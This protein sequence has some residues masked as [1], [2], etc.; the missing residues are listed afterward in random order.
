MFT[1]RMIALAVSLPFSKSAAA[2]MSLN[3]SLP[4]S[5]ITVPRKSA[6]LSISKV[7]RGASSA[8][9]V[10]LT[11]PRTLN[12]PAVTF[13]ICAL[14]SMVTGSGFVSAVMVSITVAGGVVTL[15]LPHCGASSGRSLTIKV[16]TAIVL[17]PGNLPS[18][19]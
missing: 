4:P 16:A 12:T 11:V 18:F 17:P 10:I 13:C 1:A 3:A 19:A 15:T 14:P 2:A 6:V 8:D 5:S 9:E 7:K